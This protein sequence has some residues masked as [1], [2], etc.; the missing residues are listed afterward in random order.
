MIFT[1]AFTLIPPLARLSVPCT[2]LTLTSILNMLKAPSSTVML[3]TFAVERKMDS[4]RIKLRVLVNLA[5]TSVTCLMALWSVCLNLSKMR[6][7]LKCSSGP[8]ITLLITFG[9]TLPKRLL[10][11]LSTL[12]SL[13]R[14]SS[15]MSQLLY[16]LLKVIM[17]PGLLML[18]TL[19]CLTLTTLL[20][21][22]K[23]TGLAGLMM[24]LLRNSESMDS[25]QQLLSFLMAQNLFQALK[26]LL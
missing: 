14:K 12:L 3:V 22:S 23:V 8:V 5:D 21:L 24:K 10:T 16:I 9:V 20:I 4:L 6:S 7:N 18:K 19:A 25:T 15:V 17:I 1:P 2:C 11:I 13:L 26:L